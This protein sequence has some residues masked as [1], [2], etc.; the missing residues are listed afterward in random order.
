MYLKIA[1]TILINKGSGY[2]TRS[3]LL[4]LDAIQPVKLFT[5]LIGDSQPF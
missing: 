5:R 1:F 2:S 4:V 3:G